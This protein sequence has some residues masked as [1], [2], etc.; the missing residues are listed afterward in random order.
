MDFE[1]TT[2]NMSSSGTP[3]SHLIPTN[4]IDSSQSNICSSE[5]V[6]YCSSEY[7]EYHSPNRIV[8]ADLSRSMDRDDKHAEASGLIME[9]SMGESLIAGEIK[10][11]EMHSSVHSGD[12]GQSANIENQRKLSDN[13]T[14][15]TLICTRQDVSICSLSSG[16]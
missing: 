12:L 7:V 6:E 15:G 11:S 4:S 2:Q 13:E 8:D 10:T 9:A 14:F 16:S 3:R 5:Y 1:A